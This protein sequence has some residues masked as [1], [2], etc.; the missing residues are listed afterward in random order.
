MPTVV[1][2]AVGSLAG[3]NLFHNVNQENV[4]EEHQ[5]SLDS[6]LGKITALEAKVTALEGASSGSA[7]TG[8]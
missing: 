7:S 4:L 3:L 2:L 1:P 5:D 6:Q 8:N